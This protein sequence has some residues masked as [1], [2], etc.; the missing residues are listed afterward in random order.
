MAFA[1]I[2]YLAGTVLA[3]V[4]ILV[5]AAAFLVY[6][7]IALASRWALK[8]SV[9]VYLP[10]VF[11]TRSLAA[12]DKCR[13]HKSVKGDVVAQWSAFAY[14]ALQYFGVPILLATLTVAVSW[15]PGNATIAIVDTLISIDLDLRLTDVLRTASALLVPLLVLISTFALREKDCGSDAVYQVNR[16]LY[17][18]R[19]VLATLAIVLML[20]TI[21]GIVSVQEVLGFAKSVAV[22]TPEWVCRFWFGKSCGSL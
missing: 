2:L 12:E 8:A 7:L 16:Y 20:R 18:L 21:L 10:F 22:A 11:M 3:L 1:L 15:Q 17:L 6:Y 13:F 19:V 4:A 9:F 5:I 14:L